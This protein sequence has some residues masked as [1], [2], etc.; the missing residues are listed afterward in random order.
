MIT[1]YHA[2]YFAYEL[3]K[4]GGKGLDR[5]SQSLF[6]AS[7]DLNPHQ[8]EAALFALRSPFQKGV[9]LADEV[10]LGKTIE[11]G[12]VLCQYWAER[13]RKLLIICP[14]SLR[15]QWQVELEEKFNIVAKIMDAKLF[16]QEENNGNPNPFNCSEAI[17]VSL[18]FASCM[19]GEIR[20]IQ[21]DLTVIDEAHKL[22]NSHRQS[23]K[24]GQNIRWALEDRK[25]ILLTATPLQNSLT[26]L[27]GITTVID[28]QLFGDFPTFRTLYANSDGD[29]EDLRARLGTFCRRTLRKDVLEFVRYTERKLTTIKFRPTDK[30]QHL[31]EA[32]SSYLQ[33]DGTYAFPAK[34]KHLNVLI[35]RKLLASS[36]VALAGTLDAVYKRLVT[37]RDETKESVNYSDL[38]IEQGD[39]DQ[40][41][42]DE[43]LDNMAIACEDESEYDTEF[44]VAMEP[45]CDKKINQKELEAEI[46]EVS[47]YIT[48][49]HALGVDTKTEHLLKALDVG[50]GEM[51]EMGAQEKTVIFTESRRTQDYLKEFLQNKGYAGQVVCFSGNNKDKDSQQIYEDWLTINRHTGKPTG[52]RAVDMRHAIIEYFQNSAKI[53]IA[54]EAASEGINLQ[55]C[56]MVI[57]YDLPWNPQRIEQRIGRVHRYGQK[58]DVVVINFLNARNA[59]DQRVYDLLQHKFK[60]FD[61]IFGASD[62]V[63]G[64]LD[65]SIGLEIKLLDLYQQCRTAEE[66]EDSFNKLQAELEEMISIRLDNVRQQI[67][68]YFD[69]DVH[70]VLKIDYDKALKQ[71]DSVGKYF[72]NLSKLALQ[73]HAEFNEAELSFRLNKK[74]TDDIPLG[75]YYLNRKFDHR[76][77]DVTEMDDEGKILYRMN[78]PLGEY[79]LAWGKALQLPC[80]ELHF[81]LSGYDAKISILEKL[82]GKS[83]WMILTHLAINSI[84]KEEFLLFS[85]FTDG[86]GNVDHETLRNFFKIPAIEINSGDAPENIKLRLQKDADQFVSA[87]THKVLESNN[88]LFL[89]RQEQLNCWVDDMVAA[90]ERDLKNAKAELRAVRREAIIAQTIEEQHEIQEKIRALE[91]KKRHARRKIDDVEDEAEEKRDILIKA[92]KNKMVHNTDNAPL[93]VIKWK[94]I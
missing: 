68:E 58:H 90:S 37:L 46:E 27:Y 14:A 21:W 83:G 87:T 26:E 74:L 59:A 13:K 79:C 25:K 57:N 39:L 35:I 36:P 64:K 88:K 29:L 82:K 71:L 4:T 11:A 34:Q 23:N 38:L 3:T 43:F 12:L 32:V 77:K 1:N 18:H 81:D 28:N 9:L 93:F 10:G 86:E 42:F 51:S 33:R 54:T 7:V 19:A 91:K 44:H 66:I 6:D 56:S 70:S 8:V 41:S 84:E 85:G 45:D 94:I 62:D 89:E 67:F 52:S 53:L 69:E 48:L 30:E 2:K 5:I 49:T 15:K 60:L 55:F 65:N 78:H 31:Y 20:Q 76:E 63:L 61:G 75:Y 72:W 24:M 17:I 22:R 73:D 92:L 80:K 40:E 50:F 47:K 16:L